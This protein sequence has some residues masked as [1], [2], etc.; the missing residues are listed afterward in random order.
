MESL[1]A[2][3]LLAGIRVEC[4]VVLEYIDELKV[5]TFPDLVIVEIVRRSDLDSTGSER[6]ID[7]DRVG[8]DRNASIEEGVQCKLAVQMLRRRDGWMST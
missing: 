8:D 3:E 4:T 2:L 7:D 1:H 5:V 6:H